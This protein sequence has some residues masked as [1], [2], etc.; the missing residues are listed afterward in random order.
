MGNGQ[1]RLSLCRPARLGAN[2]TAFTAFAM[3]VYEIRNRQAVMRTLYAAGRPAGGWETVKGGEAGVD[4]RPLLA[5]GA[6]S[7]LHWATRF[8]E[9]PGLVDANSLQPILL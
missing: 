6:C 1:S 2:F 5:L 3:S 4:V 9:R 7:D 8:S